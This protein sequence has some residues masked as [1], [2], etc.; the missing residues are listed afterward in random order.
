MAKAYDLSTLTCRI[1]ISTEAVSPARVAR[2]GN[3]IGRE[4]IAVPHISGAEARTSET[5]KVT[6]RR[7][8]SLERTRNYDEKSNYRQ[9]CEYLL[10]CTYNCRRSASKAILAPNTNSQTRSF[11]INPKDQ[12]FTRTDSNYRVIHDDRIPCASRRNP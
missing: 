6:E 9:M 3:L 4:S 12:R 11:L 1:A 5:T 7:S 10:S 2:H 8:S